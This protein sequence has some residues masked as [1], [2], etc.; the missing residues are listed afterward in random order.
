MDHHRVTDGDVSVNGRADQDVRSGVHGNQ[1][2]VGDRLAEER[3]TDELER[4]LPGKLRKDVEE[5]DEEVGQGQVS[6]HPVHPTEFLLPGQGLN[7]QHDDSISDECHYQDRDQ[8]GYF[9]P[10]QVLVT[11]PN[12]HLLPRRIIQGLVVRRCRWNVDSFDDDTH[13]T[14]A[15]TVRLAWRVGH[16]AVL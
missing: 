12:W 3:S 5:S 2:T 4:D 11:C 14:A 9:H 6:D 15:G 1:L 16:L 8:N 10:G 13:V 7:R